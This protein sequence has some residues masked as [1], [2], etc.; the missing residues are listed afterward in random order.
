MKTASPNER[1]RDDARALENGD[2]LL[3]IK[4]AAD[5]LA[6]SVRALYRL[7]A[8]G[9]LP[10]PVKIGRA[11]RIPRSDIERYINELK[12]SRAKPLDSFFA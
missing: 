7:V 11:T 9:Q 8:D 4:E 10:A 2:R 3:R 5:I 12:G 1:D 6:I